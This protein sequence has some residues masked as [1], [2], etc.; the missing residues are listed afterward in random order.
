MRALILLAVFWLGAAAGSFL[1]VVIYRLRRQEAWWAGRS[2]CPHCR[3]RIRWYDLF[4]LVSFLI[5]RGRCR[6]CR[7]RLARQYPLVELAAGGL[8]FLGALYLP[9]DLTLV[10]YWAAVAFF[11]VLFVYDAAYYLVPDKVSLPAI[12]VIFLLNL[13]RGLSLGPL[14]LGAALGGA[15]FL[16]QFLVSR[17]RWVGGGDIRL[18]LLLGVLLGYPLLVLGLLL[19][20]IGGSLIALFLLGLGRKK[21]DSRLPFAT[22]LLPSALAVFLWGENIWR[23]YG[24]W[25]GFGG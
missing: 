19:T 23:W 16:A 25:L 20:Y 11:T 1:Q 22:M 6:F 13:M 18:G 3:R 10:T 15:W 2:Y 8:F 9:W 4:P 24:S 21:L 7:R 12:A 5:L 14:V 17:G